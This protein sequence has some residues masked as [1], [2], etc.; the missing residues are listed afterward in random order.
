MAIE[1]L[2]RLEGRNSTVVRMLE[3]LKLR[4]A[5]NYK[6]ARNL[7]NEIDADPDWEATKIEM[8]HW[9][10]IG[11]GTSEKVTGDEDSF[12]KS[13][14]K[15]AADPWNWRLLKPQWR[16]CLDSET[17]LGWCLRALCC[18]VWAGWKMRAKLQRAVWSMKSL[19]RRMINAG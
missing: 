7:L 1:E 9:I 19:R 8:L 4:E 16:Y 11:E 6:Q 15:I 3:V 13:K 14:P 2:S 17:H 5:K 18:S 10:A 12:E